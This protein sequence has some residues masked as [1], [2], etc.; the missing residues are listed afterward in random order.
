[1]LTEGQMR[2]STIPMPLLM[3]LWL[4]FQPATDGHCQSRFVHDRGDHRAG[5]M[6]GVGGQSLLN[7]RYRYLTTTVAG[8]YQYNLLKRGPWGV[9]GMVQPHIVFTRFNI[10]DN[11]PVD[12]RGLEF[13]VNMGLIL[14]RHL[15]TGRG[16]LYAGVSSGPHFLLKDTHRQSSG[17]IFS[18][19][20]FIGYAHQVSRH[21]VVDIRP[22]YRHISNA[23]IYL[24]NGG[25]NNSTM[26][27]GLSYH[28]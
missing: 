2:P 13:G 12:Q 22:G 16:A 25:I 10:N 8:E 28:F 11:D 17:P 23:G 5:F 19:A 20:L 21:M 6:A 27:A 9:H 26:S 15:K 4:S 18:S 14:E 24:P 7:V 1:M 3:L